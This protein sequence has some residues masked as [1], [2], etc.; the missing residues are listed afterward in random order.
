[1]SIL[2]VAPPAENVEAFSVTAQLVTA[3]PKNI[4]CTWK[5]LF[6]AL[7]SDFSLSILNNNTSSFLINNS[8]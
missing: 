8:V 4:I 2:C 1:M 5:I 3:G 6:S 7:S